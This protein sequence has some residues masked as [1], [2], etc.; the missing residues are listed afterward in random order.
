MI[1]LTKNGMLYLYIK[2]TAMIGL[3]M[4]NP[5][6]PKEIEARAKA[7]S[8]KVIHGVTDTLEKAGLAG[9][10]SGSSNQFSNQ[11]DGIQQE[12]KNNLEAQFTAF[13][14]KMDVV[15]REDYELQRA[16][17]T[18]ALHRIETLEKAIDE[19]TAIQDR[20]DSNS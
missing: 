6:D 8:D 16:M 1:F 17:L 11:L 9:D 3:C 5:F 14:Q 19:I 20:S 15:T 4:N 2:V 12:I 7:F 18:Q 10:S 13:L